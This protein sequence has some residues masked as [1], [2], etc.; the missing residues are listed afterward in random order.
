MPFLLLLVSNIVLFVS[1]RQTSRKSSALTESS[2]VRHGHHGKVTPMIF[3]SS[4]ILLL[5]ISPRYFISVLLDDPFIARSFRYLLQFYLNFYQKRPNCAWT[6]F[7]PHLLKTLELFNYALNV[8]VSIVS[9]KHGRREL[10][11]MLLCRSIA[12]RPSR[13]RTSSRLVPLAT[14]RSS[15]VLK[16]AFKTRGEK[17]KDM[18]DNVALKPF[19]A[20]PSSNSNSSSRQ[21]QRS[22]HFHFQ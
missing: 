6:H 22:N 14:P 17:R 9:G 15:S 11:D 10:F 3:F 1:V 20:M 2:L 19:L 18:A 12:T 4:C 13:F 5:T 16:F 21:T 8:F 7:A